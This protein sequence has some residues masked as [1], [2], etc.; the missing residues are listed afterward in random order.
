[1]GDLLLVFLDE[2]LLKR[3]TDFLELKLKF[4]MYKYTEVNV[5]NQNKLIVLDG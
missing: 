2:L 1:M 5:I 3:F 4:F